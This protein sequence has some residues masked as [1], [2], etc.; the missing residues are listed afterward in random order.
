MS[1]SQ[2]GTDGEWT[3]SAL[4]PARQKYAEPLP[5]GLAGE[6][7]DEGGE[8]GLDPSRYWDA[9]RTHWWLAIVVGLPMSALA[10]GA[11]WRFL[12]KI[13]AT[14]AVLQVA[15]VERPLIFAT[16]D[17]AQMEQNAFDMYKRTQ[18]QLI[19]SRFV[20]TAALRDESLK[21]VAALKNEPTTDPIDWIAKNIS[22]AFPD[23]AEIM[24]VSLKSKFGEGLDQVVNSVVNAYF[25]EI[26][27]V[28]Q[29]R[30]HERLNSLEL[31][32]RRFEMDLRT[33]QTQL[34]ELIERVGGVETAD[35]SLEQQNALERYKS[36]RQSFQSVEYELMEAEL[37]QSL[38]GGET[39]D[40]ALGQ[41][42]ERAV[43]ADP[44]YQRLTADRDQVDSVIQATIK[45][46]RRPDTLEAQL[47]PLKHHLDELN[48]KMKVRRIK[49]QDDVKQQIHLG[50]AAQKD[51]TEHD[52]TFLKA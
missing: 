33:K 13:Y 2:F 50:L 52:L 48:S 41:H 10:A 8:G 17:K 22:I 1:K 29:E 35:L 24:T 15:S 45:A 23:D 36:M 12:P 3:A 47:K 28:E 40:A 37:S 39:N 14:T 49:V 43:L 30:R 26:V 46:I 51:A 42:I 21:E 5:P 20:I 9:L 6:N 18:K 16:A 4:A 31:A 27:L 34:K 32:H 19:Q 7:G 44:E 25:A 38:S 11:T